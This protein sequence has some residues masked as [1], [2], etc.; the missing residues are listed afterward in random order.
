MTNPGC[1]CTNSG[2]VMT[3]QGCLRTNPGCW[4]YHR[5]AQYMSQ[6][7]HWN[8]S[9]IFQICPRY[10]LDIS[11]KYHTY[12]TDISQIY[13]RYVLDN[14]YVS[15]LD[16]GRIT[17]AY[18]KARVTLASAQRCKQLIIRTNNCLKL[19]P[20]LIFQSFDRL[21]NLGKKGVWPYNLLSIAKRMPTYGDSSDLATNTFFFAKHFLKEHNSFREAQCT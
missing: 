8:F 1:F 10:V 7:C 18:S 11:Q 4:I 17:G 3:N 12:V 21:A 14:R 20:L 15:S 5:Y 6:I 13:P 2:L 16:K 9:E 19:E